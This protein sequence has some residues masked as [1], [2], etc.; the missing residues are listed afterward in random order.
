MR[1]KKNYKTIA[2]WTHCTATGS[3]MHDSNILMTITVTGVMAM[4]NM[5]AF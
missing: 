2:D 1:F 4:R 5:T 3:A